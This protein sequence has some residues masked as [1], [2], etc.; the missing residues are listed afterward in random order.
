M[1][2]TIGFDYVLII[3]WLGKRDALTGSQLHGYLPS[4][5]FESTLVECQ[6]P[7][8]VRQALADAAA[9]VRSAGI[10]IVHLE[11]HGSNPWGGK[12]E[13][14]CFGSGGGPSVTW[15]Q[16][17]EWLAP[18]NIASDFKLLCVSAACWGSGIMGGISGG[19]HAAPFACAVGFRT[20]VDEGRLRDA[21]KELY[22][23]LKSGNDLPECVKRAQRELVHGQKIE[24]EVGL[25]LARKILLNGSLRGATKSPIGPHR[26]RR[27]ARAVWN[28]WFPDYLQER[29]PA[30][31]FDS[32]WI[33]L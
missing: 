5:R 11:A 3:E 6:R 1:R 25:E 17:G 7:E 24:L 23:A 18:L 26:R 14:I 30:Y 12:A 19:Q 28:T 10:P 20:E 33:V 21:M 22:R 4:L 9:Q 13:D 16:L 27:R 31:R 8:D 29:D 2:V 15:S 32:A